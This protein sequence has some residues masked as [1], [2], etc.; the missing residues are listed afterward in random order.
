MEGLVLKTGGRLENI[1]WVYDEDAGKGEYVPKD[2][3]DDA[4]SFLMEP[5]RIEGELFLRDIFALLELN[6]I[7]VAVFRRDWAA[8]YLAEAKR[9]EA[10]PYTGEYDPD[11]IEYLELYQC[12]EK[13]KETGEIEGHHRLDFHGIGFELRE[14]LMQDDYVMHRKGSRIPWAIEFTPL[15][16]LLNLPLRFNPE[17]HVSVRD[18]RYNSETE[19]L[20]M[21]SPTLAQVIHGVLWEISFCGGPED[22]VEKKAELDEVVKEAREH[23]ENNKIFDA[24]EFLELDE[25]DPRGTH[26][27]RGDDESGNT[28]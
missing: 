6:P 25:A 2:V 1:R 13:T 12:W 14:D 11:G 7:L 26:A 22:V 27:E 24:S 15:A 18:A 16:K 10:A 3:T 4:A 23:M 28:K 19:T 21:S 9:V 5:L 8:E 17:V 20:R